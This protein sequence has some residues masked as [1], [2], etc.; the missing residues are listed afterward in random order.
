MN[1]SQLSL[2]IYAKKPL[3]DNFEQLFSII[4]HQ[5]TTYTT[6]SPNNSRQRTTFSIKK[7]PSQ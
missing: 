1:N 2:I 3:T 5:G 6:C 4:N 7:L